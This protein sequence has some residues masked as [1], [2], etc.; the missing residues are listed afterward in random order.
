MM[1]LKL[2]DNEMRNK[3]TGYAFYSLCQKFSEKI[4]VNILVLV[5]VLSILGEISF[6]IQGVRYQIQELFDAVTIS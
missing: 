5:N 2:L 3:Q 6:W 1:S 4:R